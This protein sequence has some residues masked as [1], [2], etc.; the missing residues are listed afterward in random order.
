MLETKSIRH[1]VLAVLP[2]LGMAILLAFF[3]RDMLGAILSS[4]FF[5]GA[6]SQE[7]LT[8]ILGFQF[9]VAA[10]IT[11]FCLPISGIRFA[12][13]RSKPEATQTELLIWAT[14]ASVS[15]WVF[16]V[17]MVGALAL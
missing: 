15:G 2:S 11:L 8:D 10:L 14:L 9:G 13:Q 12:I 6:T 3:L 4:A 17:T 5:G 1:A 7:T 16:I